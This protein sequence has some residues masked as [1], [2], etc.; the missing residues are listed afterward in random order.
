MPLLASCFFSFFLPLSPCYPV[1]AFWARSVSVEAL[2]KPQLG[3][4]TAAWW[5]EGFKRVSDCPLGDEAERK[6]QDALSP[7]PPI[8]LLAPT[9]SHGGGVWR[10]WRRRQLDATLP[11]DTAD[12]AGFLPS[13]PASTGSDSGCTGKRCHLNERRC[14]TFHTRKRPD[15]KE[16][17]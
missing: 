1:S 5:G 3:E 11:L 4:N 7:K 2:L 10:G 17:K 6:K 13:P 14:F 16:N 9:Q 15:C 12:S 8:A